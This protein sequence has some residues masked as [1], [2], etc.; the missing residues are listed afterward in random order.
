MTRHL[1]SYLETRQRA[2]KDIKCLNFHQSIHFHRDISTKF[3]GPDVQWDC[4]EG[5]LLKGQAWKCHRGSKAVRPVPPGKFYLPGNFGK[6]FV[7]VLKD[8]VDSIDETGNLPF[9]ILKPVRIILA[10]Y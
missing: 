3:Q 2:C 9:D 5:F 7:K 8:N 10:M 4:Q 1:L 6:F